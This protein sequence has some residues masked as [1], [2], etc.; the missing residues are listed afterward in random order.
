MSFLAFNLTSWGFNDCVCNPEDGSYGGMLTKLLFRTLPSCYPVGSV[1]SH[2]PFLAP[3]HLKLLPAHSPMHFPD[4]Y[5]WSRPHPVLINTVISN[6]RLV[7]AVMER[8]HLLSASHDHRLRYLGGLNTS[9]D[10]VNI[11]WND[12]VTVKSW[13]AYFSR[14]T[15]LLIRQKSVDWTR[16]GC[17]RV[18]IVGDVINML[19][20]IW[21]K[22]EF[23]RS[24]RSRA[25]SCS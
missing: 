16:S 6:Y 8:K 4:K 13:G 3:D 23:V 2:F 18:N 5:S 20:I 9:R 19:P 15:E 11:V 17:S 1:Y 24:D 22:Q 12:D 21:F 7:S 25:F 14:M 10:P